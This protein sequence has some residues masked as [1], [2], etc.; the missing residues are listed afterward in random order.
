MEI[1]FSHQHHEAPLAPILYMRD[2]TVDCQIFL[3]RTRC[4]AA[5]AWLDGPNTGRYIKEIAKTRYSN[6][7]NLL[8]SPKDNFSMAVMAGW[9][10]SSSDYFHGE[11]RHQ[12]ELTN[13]NN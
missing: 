4:N 3:E 7:P 6:I 10:W 9:L 13:D 5:Q 1:D 12:L 2:R 11:D 8:F